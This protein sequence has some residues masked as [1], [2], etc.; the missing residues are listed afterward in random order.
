MKINFPNISEHSEYAQSFARLQISP[1]NFVSTEQD[2]VESVDIDEGKHYLVC[3]E[4]GFRKIGILPADIQILLKRD[5]D[6][7]TSGV[8]SQKALKKAE[9]ASQQPSVS[10][11]QRPAKTPSPEENEEL[12]SWFIKEMAGKLLTRKILVI[13][14]PFQVKPK[15]GELAV[16]LGMI[17][18]E[19][20]LPRFARNTKVLTE[21]TDGSLAMAAKVITNQLYT[22]YSEVT[23]LKG[24]TTTDKIT[25]LN[26]PLKRTLADIAIDVIITKY[27]DAVAYRKELARWLP[28][29][30]LVVYMKQLEALTTKIPDYKPLDDE[31][32]SKTNQQKKAIINYIKKIKQPLI[33]LLKE[34][35]HLRFIEAHTPEEDLQEAID[36]YQ[37]R[38]TIPVLDLAQLDEELLKPHG[39]ETFLDI[40]AFFK[41]P[42]MNMNKKNNFKHKIRT[43]EEGE[44][45]TQLAN[46]AIDLVYEISK[47]IEL[48]MI[49]TDS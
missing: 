43:P 28:N 45:F 14:E 34:H 6:I 47:F 12:T 46:L 22:R 32:N 40:H 23:I 42:L 35:Y 21:T 27:H 25:T 24:S 39:I 48:E 9:P 8:A 19:K 17:S 16:Y 41:T 30:P 29:H 15:V 10:V 37:R 20:K 18:D 26:A 4:H 33:N 49:P 44:N 13:E 38:T 31:T 3:V 36:Y 2:P 11:E 7:S 5:L 1:K